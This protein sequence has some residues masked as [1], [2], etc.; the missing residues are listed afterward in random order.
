MSRTRELVEEEL[1]RVAT[2]YFSERG[3]QETTLDEI[4]SQVGISRV[5]FYTYFENKAA[6]LKTIFERSLR[7]YRRGLED[8]LA[9]PLPRPEKLRQV[10]NPRL[11]ESFRPKRMTLL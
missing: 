7:A 10:T 6:L 1:I 9:Q 2:K 11:G 4:V 3:Y 5:T 8:I